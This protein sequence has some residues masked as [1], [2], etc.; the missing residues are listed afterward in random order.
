MIKFE[1]VTKSYGN[2]VVVNKVNLNIKEGE[3]FCTYRSIW[4]W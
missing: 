2:K 3:F 1:D 4:I